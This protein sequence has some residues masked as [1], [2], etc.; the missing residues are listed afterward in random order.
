MYPGIRYTAV[1][2]TI[3]LLAAL[4]PFVRALEPLDWQGRIIDAVPVPQSS[5]IHAV[6]SDPPALIQYNSN[7][8]SIEILQELSQTPSGILLDNDGATSLVLSTYSDEVIRVRDES[9]PIPVGE[10]PT[11]F[12]TLPDG[13]YAVANSFSNSVSVITGT[14]SNQV[15]ATIATQSFPVRVA[16]TQ[17]FITV[18]TRNPRALTVYDARNRSRVRSRELSEVP[19]A[20]HGWTRDRIVLVYR[21]SVELYDASQNSFSNLF[22]ETADVFITRDG[23]LH[24]MRD[25]ELSVLDDTAALVRSEDLGVVGKPVPLDDGRVAV[26]D[27]TKGVLLVPV[28]AIELTQAEAPA[29]PAEPES[30][31]VAP[32]SESESPE[33][34]PTL[35]SSAP[36]LVIRREP[37]RPLDTPDY[38]TEQIREIRIA[39]ESAGS[40]DGRSKYT[41]RPGR[42]RL[43]GGRPHAPTLA[44][45]R[46]VPIEEAIQ[47]ST[48]FTPSP[49][50]LM[51]ID[52]TKDPENLDVGK[53]VLQNNQT[54]RI[55]SE[56]V[57]FTLDDALIQ[58][59][60]LDQD[61]TLGTILLEDNVS[62][63]T[64]VS[65]LTADR[66][67]I[68]REPPLGAVLPEAPQFPLVPFG[69]DL[70]VDD[71]LEHGAV[72]AY[73]LHLKEEDREFDADYAYYDSFLEKGELVNPHGHSGPF[74]FSA[75]N[76]RILGPDEFDSDD[77]W[78]T[79][80]DL[81]EPHYR[82]RISRAAFK[83]G[84]LADARN[85]RMQIGK[86][87]TPIYIPRLG[88]LRS[89]GSGI[90]SIDLEV[91]S[92]S[93]IGGYVNFAQWFEIDDNIDAAYRLFPTTR[94]GLGYGV[95][96]EYDYMEDPAAL[97]FRSR[98]SLDTLYTTEERGYTHWYHRQSLGK[99]TVLLAQWEQWYDREFYKDFYNDQY[100][101][102]SGPRTFANIT[103]RRPWGY[104]TA[105]GSKSTHDFLNET[106]KLP[107]GTLH[108]LERELVKN[109]YLTMDSY[110]GSYRSVPSDF[111]A[112]RFA[113]NARLSYDWNI[114]EGINITP[115]I[116]GGAV[117][118]SESLG[119]NESDTRWIGIF[120]TTAQT[121]FAKTYRGIGRFSEFRHIVIPSVTYF[122]QDSSSLDE[123]D[124]PRFDALDALPTR[125]RVESK[126]E[127]VILGRNEHNGDTWRV[128]RLAL[129]QGHDLSNDAQETT[130]YEVDLELRPRPWW[131]LRAV[132]EHRTLDDEPGIPGKDRD[133]IISYLF[134]DDSRFENKFNARLGFALTD[135][136]GFRLNREVLYGAGYKLSPQWSF[137]AEHRY[138]LERDELRRQVYELRRRLHKWEMALRVRD[139]PSGTD[140]NIVFSLMDIAGT[141]IRF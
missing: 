28:P 111:D 3:C 127:N 35:E 9:D 79:T 4:S 36:A 107:E 59:E 14:S 76:I 113:Q 19:V 18:V 114:A 62:A 42:I 86:V 7:D 51:R 87:D 99:R 125:R 105:T 74:Y 112:Q 83:N 140:I 121:R 118:Y 91:G 16:A 24:A 100:E 6:T 11:D 50:S 41:V 26:L 78:I 17:N 98:G 73:N 13:G 25:S 102:R 10:N 39:R 128:A 135:V 21:D 110:V 40:H 101:D 55:G 94:E 124:V 90:T 134:Y 70:S 22:A 54:K 123:E 96:V 106:E 45:Q 15:D 122:E 30:T 138:D 117:H 139:R 141:A 8:G 77:L 57:S 63:S 1:G 71:P 126:L 33:V 129:Y 34:L 131:G 85:V 93:E 43:D 66:L 32:P 65:N 92:R 104:L 67:F 12:A 2:A 72:E 103:H 95:D 108:V 88:G 132:G 89:D 120:G 53:L 81:D 38:N 64:D 116:E 44:D 46:P 58:S 137:S 84:E 119:N 49:D 31:E 29:P 109:L 97:F 20:L 68:R 80:C 37:V 130:E 75:E 133:R 61:D 48:A 60:R 47:Q 136:E 23:I 56:G 5:R 27:R 52:T 69:Y 115:F 82:I